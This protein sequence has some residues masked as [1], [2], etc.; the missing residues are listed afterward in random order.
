MSKI[1][2]LNIFNSRYFSDWS[3]LRKSNTHAMKKLIGLLLLVASVDLTAQTTGSFIDIRDGK[4]YETVTYK[5]TIA[6]EVITDLDEY[7]SYVDGGKVMYRMTPDDNIP[8]SITWM[9]QNLNFEKEESKCKSDTDKDCALYGRLYTWND[10]KSVCP[11]GWHLPSDDEWYLL[12]Y[13]YGGTAEAG[14]HLKSIELNGTNQSLFNVKK[15]SIFW[16][17]DELDEESA[18]DWKVNYRWVKLQRW[19]GG[20]NLYNSVRCVQDY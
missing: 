3:K 6:Q 7:A 17:S 19:K 16:S 20:K 1:A 11:D 5:I 9:A 2:V 18:L 12:A 4:T 15:P 14:Q 10:A 8:T 13:L